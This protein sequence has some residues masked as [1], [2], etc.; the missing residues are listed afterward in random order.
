MS[1][2]V[3]ASPLFAGLQAPRPNSAAITARSAEGDVIIDHGAYCC[4]NGP[5]HREKVLSDIRAGYTGYNHA[6][7]IAQTALGALRLRGVN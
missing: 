5:L 6:E 4:A 1:F 7:Y 2:Q 3:P